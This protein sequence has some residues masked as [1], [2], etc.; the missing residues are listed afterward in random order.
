[1]TE[2]TRQRRGKMDRNTKEREENGW[3]VREKM[4]T[5]MLKEMFAEIGG[6]W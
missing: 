6:V 5:V 4:C 3:D 1:M 2:S